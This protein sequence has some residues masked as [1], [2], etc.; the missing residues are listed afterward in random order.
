M[1]FTGDRRDHGDAQIFTADTA[2]K[3]DGFP[4]SSSALIRAISGKMSWFRLSV[5]VSP[6]FNPITSTIHLNPLP[7]EIAET[8]KPVWPQKAQKAQ[9]I[10]SA[11]DL[12]R[13][14]IPQS[15]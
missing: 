14:R 6:W 11:G 15:V 5:F 7:A 12:A 10:W 2:D 1:H 3:T 13:E 4:I 8:P 9:K